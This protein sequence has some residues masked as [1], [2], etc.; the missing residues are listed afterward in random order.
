MQ[1]ETE[2]K[3]E[4]AG[5]IKKAGSFQLF[6][7]LSMTGRKYLFWY[8]SLAIAALAVSATNLLEVEG[9]RRIIN[10][11]TTKNY[12]ALIIGVTLSIT[13]MLL[14]QAIEFFKSYSGS[15]LNFVSVRNL[16]SLLIIKIT[17]V[18]F[19]KYDTFHTGDL[20]DRL[21]NSST[22][23]QEGL[24]NT[25]TGVFQNVMQIIL[26]IIYLLTV[27][28]RLTI[29][30]LLFSA[31]LPVVVSPL[32]KKLKVLY[33]ESMQL[34]A[35]K[36]AMIQDAIQGAEI[37]KTYK[38]SDYFTNRL[39]G[40]YVKII[41]NVRKL[42]PFESLMFT[43]NIMII[44]LGDFTI[45]A[46]GGYLASKGQLR[47]GDVITFVILFEQMFQPI[48]YIASVWPQFQASLASAGRVFELL[49]L[50]EEDTINTNELNSYNI[51]NITGN[52]Q[53]AE[54]H[55]VPGI[56][57]SGDL[58][59]EDVTFGYSDPDSG[60]ILKNVSFT[61]QQGKVTAIVGPSGSGKSTL[62]KLALNLYKPSSGRITYGS[63]DINKLNI[64]D[65]RSRLSYVPQE[66]SMFTGT[67]RENI[68][69]GK[70]DAEFDEIRQAAGAA[71]ILD[72]IESRNDGFE[73]LTG[74]NGIKLSGGERQRLSIA[75]AILAGR[76]ILILD[77]PTSALDNENEKIVMDA[78]SKLMK[79]QTT[80]VVAHRLSTIINAD[81]IIYLEN[82]EVTETGTHNELIGLKGRYYAMYNTMKESEQL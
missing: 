59:F 29:A 71:N 64:S 32:S 49:D 70:P 48:S 27:N 5:V 72:F 31:I 25:L 46:F 36:S 63:L 77:E 69:Y 22:Q 43:S 4:P 42:I 2:L 73:E 44:I 53:D 47:A 12:Q 58:S 19:N 62:V 23:A 60:Y 51:P 17:K 39:A 75:R 57:T 30:A 80:I 8:I 18:V 61:A 74:E 50:E 11:A 1:T 16:Q 24:N 34:N 40:I 45:L 66:S 38:L 68:S 33:D 26:I 13:A 15:L 76:S 78:L 52:L 81:R 14:G 20:S 67:I 37:V 56:P 10:A 9:L 82:G 41:K 65:W 79:N 7:R 21:K 28:L 35:D 54:I 55:P 3:R 6:K